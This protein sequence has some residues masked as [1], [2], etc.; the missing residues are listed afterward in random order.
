MSRG[1]PMVLPTLALRPWE[2]TFAASDH[3]TCDRLRF[4]SFV[5]PPACQARM[6]LMHFN[7]VIHVKKLRMA[8]FE[9]DFR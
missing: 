4:A 6:C 9:M 1:P 5:S 8:D 2:A 3:P 7:A